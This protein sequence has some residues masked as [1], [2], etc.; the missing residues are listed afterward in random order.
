MSPR[1]SM[2]NS[3]ARRIIAAATA[4]ALAG[5]ATAVPAGPLSAVAQAQTEYQLGATATKDSLGGGDWVATVRNN[6]GGYRPKEI[7]SVRLNFG[8]SAGDDRGF[9]A[10]DIYDVRLV[11]GIEKFE[12]LGSVEGSGGSDDSGNRWLDLDLPVSV[13]LTDDVVLEIRKPGADSSL[14]VGKTGT[15]EEFTA[16]GFIEPRFRE[17]RGSVHYW[18]SIQYGNGRPASQATVVLLDEQYREV[19]R[20]TAYTDG[21]FHFT[22][23]GRGST[24]TIRV[25]QG[26]F[27]HPT[28]TWDTTTGSVDSDEPIVIHRPTG[29]IYLEAAGLPYGTLTVRATSNDETRYFDISAA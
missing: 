19:Q 23:I 16:S 2:K 29:V 8:P 9:P 24:Y 13:M 3:R 1:P 18:G 26:D 27:E 12:K 21:S 15:A 25:I 7:S 11:K 6:D 17:G 4:L 20:T 10:K 22:G 14:P 5:G 28:V